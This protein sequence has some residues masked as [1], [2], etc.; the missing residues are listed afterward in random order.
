MNK[1]Q[2]IRC[3][4]SEKEKE[5]LTKIAIKEGYNLSETIRLLIREAALKWNVWKI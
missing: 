2:I 1:N 3:R 5:V 4:V